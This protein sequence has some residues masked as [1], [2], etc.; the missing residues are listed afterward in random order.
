MKGLRTQELESTRWSHSGNSLLV[1]HYFA[2]NAEKSNETRLSQLINCVSTASNAP[3]CVLALLHPLC[4]IP[5]AMEACKDRHY[6]TN[7]RGR[8]RESMRKQWRRRRLPVV[9]LVG[10]RT[11]C[12]TP[13]RSPMMHGD[14]SVSKCEFYFSQSLNGKTQNPITRC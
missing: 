13:T 10:G 11:H 14:H 4:F 1:R 5:R 3:E 12:V 8:K 7:C 2:S 9:G 6:I